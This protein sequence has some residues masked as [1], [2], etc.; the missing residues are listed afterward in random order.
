M[1]A[2]TISK[3]ETAQTEGD[4]QVTRVPVTRV[5]VTRVVE[6]YNLAAVIAVCEPMR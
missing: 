1:P 4:R 5:P 6:F 3:M 2:A